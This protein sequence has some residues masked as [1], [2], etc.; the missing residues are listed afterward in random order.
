MTNDPALKSVSDTAR[1]YNDLKTFFANVHTMFSIR[2]ILAVDMMTATP[3]GGVSQRLQDV[4][5]V[6][7]RIYAETTSPTVTNLLAEVEAQ[8]AADMDDWDAANLHE[9]RRIHSHLA[10][11]PPNI[12]L[13][14]VRVVNEGRRNHKVA[15]Q[16]EDWNKAAIYM[17]QVV[18]L[19]RKIAELKQKAF[20]SST[21]YEALLS[22]YGS[23]LDNAQIEELYKNLSGGLTGLRNRIVDKQGEAN[24]AAPGKDI[25]K[26][27]QMTFVQNLLQHMGLDFKRMYLH[28]TSGSPYAGGTRDDVRILVRTIAP[29]DYYSFVKDGLYQGARALYIQ[30]L[31]EEWKNQ[32]VGQHQGALLMNAIS[33]LYESVIGRMKCFGRYLEAH[34]DGFDPDHF[35]ATRRHVRASISRNYADEISKISHDL[36]RYRIEKDLISGKLEVTG[37]PERW[38]EESRAFLGVE[39]SKLVEGPLQNPDWFTGRFGFIPTNTMSHIMAVAMYNKIE[40]EYPD[41]QDRIAKGDLAFVGEWLT[42]HIFSKGRSVGAVELV[43]EATGMPLNQNHL[44][45]HFENRYIDGLR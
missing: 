26:R 41:A 45:A 34:L 1:G 35:E 3:V 18:D 33:I 23:D 14:A 40:S 32:P 19:Y 5:S 38:K 13:A 10:A 28:A 21:P 25:D 27:T 44:I 7:K 8:G 24:E 6:T 43:K 2:N 36:M 15:L 17:Q 12:Y 9:M 4:A 37:L 20:N 39:P 31:P 29:H 22:G 42:Q 16:D 30:N 11:L